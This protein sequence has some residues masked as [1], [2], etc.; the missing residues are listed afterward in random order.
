M[1]W[2]I[3]DDNV[4]LCIVSI[5]TFTQVLHPSKLNLSDWTRFCWLVMS[6]LQQGIHSSEFRFLEIE[7]SNTLHASG[8]VLFVFGILLWSNQNFQEHCAKY[9]GIAS[10]PSHTMNTF[11][12][13]GPSGRQSKQEIPHSIYLATVQ[14]T[15]ETP[16]LQLGICR[17]KCTSLHPLVQSIPRALGIALNPHPLCHSH[18]LMNLPKES[19][20]KSHT[21]TVF[22]SCCCSF[23]YLLAFICLSLSP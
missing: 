8:P 13:H 19:A 22:N 9:E 17:S 15:R 6:S 16:A 14:S 3:V 7:H 18:Q 2:S 12:E 11:H 20:R 21:S 10:I 4:L 23:T 1:S 5:R